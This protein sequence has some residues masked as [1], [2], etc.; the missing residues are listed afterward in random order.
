MCP[1]CDF[2]WNF[3]TLISVNNRPILRLITLKTQFNNFMVPHQWLFLAM[4]TDLFLV[5]LLILIT[6]QPKK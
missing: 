6:G 1:V 3:K 5:L 2:I 4:T